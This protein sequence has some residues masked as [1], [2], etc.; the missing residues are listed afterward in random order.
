ML[1][2]NAS[3]QVKSSV[4]VNPDQRLV[5]SN[6][7]SV[8]SQHLDQIPHFITKILSNK[9]TSTRENYWKLVALNVKLSGFT[10]FSKPDQ[11]LALAGSELRS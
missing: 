11:I 1:V 8:F 4:L 10:F 9:P 6:I 3:K 2:S 7:R 5:C